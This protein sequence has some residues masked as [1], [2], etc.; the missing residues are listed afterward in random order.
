MKRVKA[1]GIEV[2]IFE[3]NL[4]ESTFLIPEFI[5]ACKNLKK[6]LI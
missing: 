1:K 3:P 5:Q 2:I 4:N 6:S